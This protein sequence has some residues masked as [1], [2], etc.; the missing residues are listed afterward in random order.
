MQN[1]PKSDILVLVST[2]VLTVVF[3]LVV[4]IEVGMILSLV[5]FMKRMSDVARIRIWSKGEDNSVPDSERLKA[6]PEHIEVIEFD[7]PM[8]FASSEKFNAFPVNEGITTVILRMRNVPALDITAMR[9]LNDIYSTCNAKG[10]KFIL[11]H[12]NEQPL[13]VMKKSGFYDRVGAENFLPNSDESHNPRT[14]SDSFYP[15]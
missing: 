8:F 4:A 6:V 7:G 14:L 13:S 15:Q 3:D 11:S 1:R 5:L 2:F 9:A 12:T 10:L